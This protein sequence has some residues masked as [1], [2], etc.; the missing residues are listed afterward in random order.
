MPTKAVAAGGATGL[1][2][3]LA[4]LL[5]GALGHPVDPTLEQAATTVIAAVLSF[6]A[7]YFTKS[8]AA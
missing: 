7:T 8:E 4:T 5:F 6:A 2:G 3:A 1:A